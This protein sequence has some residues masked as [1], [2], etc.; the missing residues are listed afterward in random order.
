MCFHNED[1]RSF[2]RDTVHLTEEGQDR[3]AQQLA[4]L[5]LRNHTSK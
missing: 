3:L 2:Y 5:I 4:S 1:L